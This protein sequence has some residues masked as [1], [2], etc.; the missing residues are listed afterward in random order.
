[1]AVIA[2]VRVVSC[3][4]T[5]SFFVNLTK[6]QLRGNPQT[7]PSAL[8]AT[9]RRAGQH[10]PERLS[11]LRSRAC[12]WSNVS[13]AGHAVR[14][15][16]KHRQ[17]DSTAATISQASASI[18]SPHTRDRCL[19][20]LRA[21]PPLSRVSVCTQSAQNANG[22]ANKKQMPACMVDT[23]ESS[24]RPSPDTTRPDAKAPPCIGPICC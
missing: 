21:P 4:N 2:N 11:P 23:P 1:M 17:A 9:S 13:D 24:N 18:V 7:R 22:D 6:L 12:G 10:Q 16:R 14:S 20:C 8:G 5:V 3:T 19:F 15:S